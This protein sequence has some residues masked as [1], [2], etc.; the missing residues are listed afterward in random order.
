MLVTTLRRVATHLENLAKSGNSR[1]VRENGKSHW[2]LKSVSLY[3]ATTTDTSTDT[4]V[5]YCVILYLLQPQ[6][7][8]C[9]ILK[10]Q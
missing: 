6:C 2:K 1:M 3:S 5:I 8:K 9:Q 4:E 10:A 7:I